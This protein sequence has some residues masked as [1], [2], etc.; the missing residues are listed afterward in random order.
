M[1]CRDVEPFSNSFTYTF[2][3]VIGEIRRMLFRI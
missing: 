3:E 2:L 1:S